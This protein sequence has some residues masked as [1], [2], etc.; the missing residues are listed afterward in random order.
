M[1]ILLFG[2]A[3]DPPH[4]GHENILKAA[5]KYKTFDK[6]II[7]PTGTPGH[8]RECKVPFAIRKHMV[9]LAFADICDNVD[10]EISDFEGNSFNKS[11]SYITVRQLK[12]DYP[13]ANIYFVIG[14][15]SAINLD[16]WKNWQQLATSVTFLV[17]ARG[18]ESDE[19]LGRAVKGIKNYS[20]MTTIINAPVINASSTQIRQLSSEN[21][22]IKEFVSLQ[23]AD[24]ISRHQLY[25]ADYYT[26]TIGTAKALVPLMMDKKRATHTFN[27]AKLAAQLA[28]IHKVDENQATLCALLH[29]I[30]KQAP[31][32]VLL[33]RARQSDIIEKINRKP[34]PVLHGFA[35][36]DYAQKEMN[37]TDSDTLMAIKSHTCGRYGMSVMEKIIYLAD[38]LCEERKFSQKKYLLDLAYTD[39]DTAM[40]QALKTNIMWLNKKGDRIDSDSFEALEYFKEINK[41]K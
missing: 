1:D 7:M 25:S 36:A 14:A 9:K 31:K 15:D 17:F 10:M 24:Y 34:L 8:K 39:L 18:G 27:V 30:M 37:I 28:N 29:D 40:E 19:R 6:V 12:K 23:V 21:K 13:R 32:D 41:N 11:Y 5:L 20:P 35:A 4:K 26:R 38:M 16:K 33:H 22:A 3:F 2:G